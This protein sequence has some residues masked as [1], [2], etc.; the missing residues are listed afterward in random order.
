MN[1]MKDVLTVE[2]AAFVVKKGK[3][4]I[5]RWIGEGRLESWKDIDG[6]TVVATQDV[7]RVEAQIKRGRPAKTIKG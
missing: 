6:I 7:T 4:T 5:H 3:S 2:E 1:H